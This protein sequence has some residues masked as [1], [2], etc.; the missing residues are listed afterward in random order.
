M[1]RKLMKHELKA[2]ARILVPL[3][4]VLLFISVVNRFMYKVG[5]K[6]G[7]FMFINGF[8][9]VFQIFLIFAVLAS[10]IIFMI[11]R[12]YK[13]L[14]SDEGYLMF[15]L[16]V[17]SHHLI[18]SKLTVAVMW[19]I[20]SIIVLLSSLLIAFATPESVNNFINGFKSNFAELVIAFDGNW[21]LL[22]IELISLILLSIV[23]NI[24]MVYVSIAVGQLFTKHKI[25]GSF[26]SYVIFYNAIQFLLL[27]LL[28]IFSYTYSGSIDFT[29]ALPRGIFPISISVL[30]VESIA[31]YVITNYMLKRKLNLD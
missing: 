21:T 4:L 17:K 12:F 22:W 26:V 18:T 6:E 29:H 16:P 23:A 31:F 14:L 28:A 10:T 13:N 20:T 7:I 3:C 5:P 27:I 1:L 8:M 11:T 15:T 30:L 24:L 19:T 2:T 25:I 9:F